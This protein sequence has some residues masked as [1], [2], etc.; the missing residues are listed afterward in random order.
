MEYDLFKAFVY[1]DNIVKKQI[2]SFT[3]AQ[4]VLSYHPI[5]ST[6]RLY[7][8]SNR[9]LQP[10]SSSAGRRWRWRGSALSSST[11]SAGSDSSVTSIRTIVR[12]VHHQR[13]RGSNIC[14]ISDQN[15]VK[16]WMKCLYKNPCRE[17]SLNI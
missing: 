15:D 9:R 8:Y 12:L 13:K 5:C 2:F 3:H 10:V 4:R 11:R 1:I 17:S 14:H 7:N 6:I 16:I